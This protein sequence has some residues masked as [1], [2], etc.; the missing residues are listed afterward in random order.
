MK[1]KSLLLVLRFSR[2]KGKNSMLYDTKLQIVSSLT[3]QNEKREEKRM[4]T[5]EFQV[6]DKI[7]RFIRLLCLC[8]PDTLFSIYFLL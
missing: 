4:R 1:T 5:I 3:I 8:S 6:E 2:H 7:R